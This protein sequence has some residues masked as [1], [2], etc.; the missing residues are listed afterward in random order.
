MKPLAYAALVLSGLLWGVGFPLGKLALREIDAAHMVTLRLVFAGLAA[1]PFALRRRETRA[2]F[3]HPWVLGGGVLFALAFLVQFEGL[4]RIN[5]SLAALLV[6]AM[7]AL[8]AVAS[9]LAGD[10]V[11]RLSWAGVA[12]A[13]A[14]AVLIG[15]RPGAG[16]SP[17]GVALSVTA[18][19]LF[20]AWL[21]SLRRA[22]S[23][24]TPTAMPAVTM[25]IAAAVLVPLSLALHGAPRLELSA[26]AWAAIAAQGVL[27]TLLATAAWQFGAAQVGAATAGVFLNLEP[28]VGMI[29]GVTLFGDPLPLTLAAGGCAII[30]GSVLVVMGERDQ[31]RIAAE[32]AEVMAG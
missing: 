9:R 13:T 4:A 23:P 5:V 11:S 10:R 12:A 15:A 6:G 24:P 17:L 2:L 20:L 26:R 28:L 8:I 14:G 27:C 31:G 29:L 19:F 3:A 25:I 18:L 30:A 32:T 16:G 21:M 22:P 1:T 7:P